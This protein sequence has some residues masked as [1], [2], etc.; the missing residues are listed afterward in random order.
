M[1]IFWLI[2]RILIKKEDDSWF[3]IIDKY[4]EIEKEKEEEYD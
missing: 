2:M 4:E 1:F 3:G